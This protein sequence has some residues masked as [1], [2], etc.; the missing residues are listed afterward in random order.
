MVFQHGTEF[1]NVFIVLKNKKQV[2]HNYPFPQAL[3]LMEQEKSSLQEKLGGVQQELGTASVEYDRLK[4]EAA[5]KQEQDRGT[6][7]SLQ[8]ELKNFRG[9]F[10]DTW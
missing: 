3:S 9:Q 4:R 1:A 2:H 6:I 8:S 10:E 5:S 7:N